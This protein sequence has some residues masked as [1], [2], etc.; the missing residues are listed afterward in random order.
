LK[1]IFVQSTTSIQRLSTF[2]IGYLSET[3]ILEL[4]SL[5]IA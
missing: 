3:K 5:L 1:L 4:E 2:M